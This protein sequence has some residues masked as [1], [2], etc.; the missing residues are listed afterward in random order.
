MRTEGAGI[1]PHLLTPTFEEDPQKSWR[2]EALNRLR[3]LNA[4]SV[5]GYQ[6]VTLPRRADNPPA[7]ELILALGSV[8]HM[9][10]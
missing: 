10:W 6:V 4:D 1:E 7:G 9:S 5:T 3:S 2:E 8:A